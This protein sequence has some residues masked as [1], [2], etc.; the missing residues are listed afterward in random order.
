MPEPRPYLAGLAGE[1]VRACQAYGAE[2]HGKKTNPARNSTPRPL[3]ESAKRGTRLE[4]FRSANFLD[5][6]GRKSGADESSGALRHCSWVNPPS[7][8]DAEMATAIS[9]AIQQEGTAGLSVDLGRGS[10]PR[11]ESVLQV[12]AQLGDPLVDGFIRRCDGL[13]HELRLREGIKPV[14]EPKS[15]I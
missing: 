14:A 4:I 2:T 12:L 3:F 5:D 10:L 15:C 11:S 6:S 1:A 7:T 9:S 8:S 13:R